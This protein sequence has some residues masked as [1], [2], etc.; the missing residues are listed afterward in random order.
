LS[1]ES[2]FCPVLLAIL[3]ILPLASGQLRLTQ[4]LEH[5]RNDSLSL[6][7]LHWLFERCLERGFFLLLKNL[8]QS[9]ILIVRQ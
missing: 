3:L 4:S 8:W 2:L 1:W 7:F 6:I 9:L 5:L